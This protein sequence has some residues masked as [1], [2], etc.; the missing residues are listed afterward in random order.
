MNR[1]HWLLMPAI[2]VPAAIAAPAFATQ[3]LNVE[4]A[5]RVLLPEA[6][7]FEP[8]DVA[9]TPPLK[10]RIE[11]ASGVRVRNPL[12][13][14]WRAESGGKTVGWFVVDEVIGKHEFITYAV[15]L[16]PDGVV[17]GVEILDYR[18]THGGEIRNAR[19]RAQFVGK[20][21]G[22]AFQLDEDIRNI[23]GAT[24]S[25]KNVTN[26]VKRILATY[27]LTLR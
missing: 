3:Y 19:W 21:N 24:L 13:K 9:I 20:K 18:E 17:K 10:E 4:Q 26:G 5:Q 2:V 7:A 11:K 23:S 8:A 27:Q 22:D 14:A 12:L 6:T 15:A 25:C 16:T 1:P